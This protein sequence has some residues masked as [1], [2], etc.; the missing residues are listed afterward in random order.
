MA[1]IPI[2]SAK[3]ALTEMKKVRSIVTDDTWLATRTLVYCAELLERI[4]AQKQRKKRKPTAWSTFLGKQMRAGKNPREAAQL[5]R[6]QP[7]AK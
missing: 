7:R 2:T 1:K 4:A 6:A 3:Q 5:W